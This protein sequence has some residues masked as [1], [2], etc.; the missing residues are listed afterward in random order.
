MRNELDQ[1]TGGKFVG[2]VENAVVILRYL[3]HASGPLGV[4]PIARETGLNVST[5]FNILRTLTK[6]GLVVFDTRTKSYRIGLGVLEFSAPLLGTAQADLI[7]PEL[8][9]LSAES[10]S[11]IGLW[12]ITPA[13]RIVLVD[14]VVGVN[15]VRVDISI[16]SRLP[17]FIGA[18]GRCVAATRD[19]SR[20]EL[21]EQFKPL[22]WQ[23]P[24]SF[25][26]YASDV[27]EAIERGYAFDL[28]QLFKGVDIAA[29]VIRD[30][31]GAARFGI[32]AIV[33]AGQMTHD[34]L[35]A[36]AIAIRDT[37]DTV[38]RN[39]YGRARAA[40]ENEPPIQPRAARRRKS[41]NTPEEENAG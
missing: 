11:L 10:R 33:I 34:E 17:A 12:K 14:R 18:V 29:A 15:T 38:A 5:T 23:D 26:S 40:V 37:A 7:H 22:R 6:E 13:D 9:R 16:G 32:S 27:E 36:L 2:A 21:L 20:S 31:T 30:H 41:S 4:A 25:D 8:E 19:L 28:Q 39:L 24:P 1:A 3:A 35:G